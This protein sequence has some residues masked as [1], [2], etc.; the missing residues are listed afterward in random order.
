MVGY[1][2][3]YG[4]DHSPFTYLYPNK[5]VA[6]LFGFSMVLEKMAAILFCF[7]FDLGEM[8]AILFKMEHHWKTEHKA[9]FGIPNSSVFQPLN[10]P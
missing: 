6:I 3:S 9:T 4:P 1:S 8:A 7:P 10:V 5:M 2:Y